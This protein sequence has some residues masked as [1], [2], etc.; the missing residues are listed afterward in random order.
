M[1]RGGE[2]TALLVDRLLGHR[3]AVIR[4]LTDPLVQVV[5]VSGATDLGDG[6]PT[7]VL[8]LIA[9]VGAVSGQR[10]ALRPEGG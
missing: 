2:A 6:K 1:R 8:D 5:G 4:P 7:L 9:L 3:E 10:T